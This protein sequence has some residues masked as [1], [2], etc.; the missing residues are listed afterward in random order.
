MIVVRRLKK[1]D[2]LLM[3]VIGGM[4]IEEGKENVCGGLLLKHLLTSTYIRSIMLFSS[5]H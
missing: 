5:R 3:M 1:D 2:D 4:W